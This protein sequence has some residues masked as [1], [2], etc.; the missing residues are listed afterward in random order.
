L[1]ENLKGNRAMP[2]KNPSKKT[3]EIEAFGAVYSALQ[4]LDAQKQMRVLRYVAEMLD[5]KLGPIDE[6]GS[7][8]FEKPNDTDSEPD[9]SK[10]IS[11]ESE[12]DEAEGISAVAL[13]WIRRSGLDL[14]SLQSLFSLGIDEIDLVAKSIPGKKKTERMR[15]VLLLKGI[16][17]YLG[18]GAARVTYEQLKEACLHYGAYDA[19]NFASYLKS[20]SADVGGSKESGFTLSARGLTSATA[21]IKEMTASKS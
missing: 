16:A 18:T 6:S 2:P 11:D 17:A 3:P 19:T 7:E 14:K 4:G 8:R 1:A 5:L 21:L 20:F 13:K 15:N 10:A 9:K 12:S